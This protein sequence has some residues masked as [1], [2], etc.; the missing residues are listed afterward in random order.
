MAYITAEWLG[1]VVQD[2][3][4][5]AVREAGRPEVQDDIEKVFKALYGGPSTGYGEALEANRAAPEE[6]SSADQDS[7]CAE[8]RPPASLAAARAP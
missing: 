5:E 6:P 2:V 7:R 1:G 4:M 3:L 8:T